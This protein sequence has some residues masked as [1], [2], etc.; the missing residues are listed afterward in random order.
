MNFMVLTG[1]GLPLA[2]FEGYISMEK[3]LS[4]FGLTALFCVLCLSAPGFSEETA[5]VADASQMT[6]VQDVVAE[7]MEPVYAEALYDGVYEAAVDSSSSMFRIER[8]ALQVEDGELTAELT[9]SSESY[10]Y[11]YPGTAAEAAAAAKS[12]YLTPGEDGRT[13]TLPIPALDTGVSC[14]AW[15]RNKEL[16]YDRT[17]V[18]RSDSLPLAAFRDVKTVESLALA[19]GVYTVEAA[20]EGGSGRAKIQ[21]PCRLWITDGAAAAEI[22]WGSANYDYMKVDSKQIPAEIRDEHS[23][24]V[25]PVAA[26]DRSLHVIADTTA[27][28]KPHEIEYTLRFDAETITPAA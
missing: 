28:S 5:K 13:F 14:A 17:L 9:M 8:C 10:G 12:A 16:W 11:L 23:V 20:L 22:V 1:F 25:I 7:G 3:I 18:F 19:D 4:V 24:C 21:S 26:F 15:S 27:M 6:T 2:G